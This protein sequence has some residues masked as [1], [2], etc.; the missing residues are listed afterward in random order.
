MPLIRTR[1]L[2]DLALALAVL[3]WRM[4]ITWMGWT[5]RG[6]S[7]DKEDEGGTPVYHCHLHY[8]DGIHTVLLLATGECFINRKSEKLAHST[9]SK[10]KERQVAWQPSYNTDT[11]P[12]HE[13][14]GGRRHTD[15][16]MLQTLLSHGWPLKVSI[17]HTKSQCR[18]HPPYH[19]KWRLGE[20]KG[21]PLNGTRVEFITSCGPTAIIQSDFSF[22]YLF[23]VY[24]KKKFEHEE[25][26]SGIQIPSCQLHRLYK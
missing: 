9:I 12:R 19:F 16:N 1:S 17:K 24:I 3:L 7:K 18:R 5:A 6:H 15:V 2:F 23:L 8:L 14:T 26:W 13:S 20:E 21:R 10:S 11:S 25:K 22:I 4:L